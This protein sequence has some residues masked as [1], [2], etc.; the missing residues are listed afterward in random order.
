MG[1]SDGAFFKLGEIQL[2]APETVVGD[3]SDG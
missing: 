2:E 1:E 3:G